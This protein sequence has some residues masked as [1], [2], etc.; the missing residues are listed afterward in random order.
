MGARFNSDFALCFRLLSSDKRADLFPF[1]RST[2]ADTVNFYEPRN[3]RSDDD[4]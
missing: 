4:W 2:H 3:S 1:A